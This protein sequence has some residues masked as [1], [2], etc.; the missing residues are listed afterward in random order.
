MTKKSKE[1]TEETTNRLNLEADYILYKSGDYSLELFNKLI[2][3]YPENYRNKFCKKKRID[4]EVPKK[5]NTKVNKRQ[6][7]LI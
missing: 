3:N 1:T 6:N 5:K 2:A 7:K 4:L